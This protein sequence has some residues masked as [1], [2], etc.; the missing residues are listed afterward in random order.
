MLVDVGQRCAAEQLVA[1]AVALGLVL[2]LEVA[3]EVVAESIFQSAAPA[4]TAR[5]PLVS[6]M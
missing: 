1:A 2:V 6:F 3:L 5:Q 4:P